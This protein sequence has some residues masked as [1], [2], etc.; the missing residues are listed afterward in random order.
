MTSGIAPVN[1]S[2]A[3]SKEVWYDPCDVFDADEIKIFWPLLPDKTH[4][5]SGETCTG[6]KMS[7]ERTT[8]LV[9]DNM[10]D[11]VEN[12]TFGNW[13]LGF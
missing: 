11:S 6:G 9:C 2:P 10:T 7:K 13:E 3:S 8:I 12:A 1:D 4:A 5:V